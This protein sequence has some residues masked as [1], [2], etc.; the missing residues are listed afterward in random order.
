MNTNQEVIKT[1][2]L[3]ETLRPDWVA[4]DKNNKTCKIIDFSVSGGRRIEGK[5]KEKIEKYQDLGVLIVNND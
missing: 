3:M 4:V 5:E 2:H 1:D